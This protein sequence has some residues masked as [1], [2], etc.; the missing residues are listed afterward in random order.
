MAFN[1]VGVSQF[2]LL[3]LL[4]WQV[5]FVNTSIKG[6]NNTRKLTNYHLISCLFY[7]FLNLMNS[8]SSCHLYSFADRSGARAAIA[9]GKKI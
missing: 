1:S 6:S 2:I 3:C 7:W 4:C 9:D 8:P 5:N